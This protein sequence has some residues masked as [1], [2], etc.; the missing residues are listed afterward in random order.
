MSPA[1]LISM[2]VTANLTSKGLLTAAPSIG[3]TNETEGSA[4]CAD[5]AS[6]TVAQNS[7]CTNR[8]AMACLLVM[9]IGY[10]DDEK[11]GMPDINRSAPRC[12]GIC[13]SCPWL[14]PPL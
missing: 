8:N 10:I 9:L 4:A 5:E 6:K 3:A 2:P 11:P 13:C 12:W 7:V 14:L 1:G